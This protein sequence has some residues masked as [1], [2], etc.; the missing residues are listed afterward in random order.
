MAGGKWAEEAARAQFYLGQLKDVL[1]PNETEGRSTRIFTRI[2]G[3]ARFR[4]HAW[5]KISGITQRRIRPLA[6][7]LRRVA[8]PSPVRIRL[9]SSL[10]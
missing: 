2:R 3:R 10:D 1:I 5:R 9:V 7:R 4:G 8:R 6:H